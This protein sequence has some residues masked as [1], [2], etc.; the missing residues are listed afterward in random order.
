M[1][2]GGEGALASTPMELLVNMMMQ[3]NIRAD[4]R[5]MEFYHREDQRDQLREASRR[6]QGPV[7][8]E[9]AGDH[10]VPVF[11]GDGEDLD[12]IDPVN[13]LRK[14][15]VEAHSKN[16]SVETAM[17]EFREHLAG[18]ALGWWIS[19]EAS[20]VGDPESAKNAFLK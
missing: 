19:H 2:V 6:S 11:S 17:M 12:A 10:T 3:N 14:L 16:W 7:R 13:F 4:E 5:M 9:K 8:H 18:S 15:A 1:G 20:F